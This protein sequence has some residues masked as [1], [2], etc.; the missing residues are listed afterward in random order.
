MKIYVK[1]HKKL[2]VYLSCE[3]KMHF[4]DNINGCLLFQP[5]QNVFLSENVLHDLSSVFML[6]IISLLHFYSLIVMI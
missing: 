1:L 4:T 3:V 6:L 2:M 5:R